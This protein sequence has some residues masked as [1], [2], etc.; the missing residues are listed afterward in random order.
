MLS[1]ELAQLVA[2][3]RRPAL[4]WAARAC[5]PRKRMTVSEH[6]DQHRRLSTKGSAM[7]GKW[8]TDANPP[9]RE[10]MDALSKHSPV[11]EVVLKFPIQFGK[12]EVAV[13]WLGYIMDHDPGP[14]MV[15][16]PGEA[17]ME[18]WI[19]QKLNPAIEEGEVMRRAMTSTKS[20]ESSNQ[21]AFKDFAGGQLFIEHAG[22]PARL[23]SNSVEKLIVDELDEFA[24]Q[25]KGGDDPVEMLEGRTSAFPVTGKRLYISSPQLEGRSRIDAKWKLSDQRRYYVPCPH[26]GHMQPLEWSGLHWSPDASHAWY[27]CRDC[28]CVIEEHHKPQMIRFGRWVAENPGAK[29]RG[30]QINCLYYQ[31]AL[32]PRWAQ[33]A[34]M[35]V[36]AQADPAKLKV[37]V[38][39]RLAE[40]WEDPAMRSVKHNVLRDRAEPYKLRQAPDGVLAIT[41]GVDTQ[42]DR[43]EVQIIGWGRGLAAWTLDYV[44]LP[45]D[46]A[47]ADV[48]ALLTEL[49]NRPIEHAS[50]VLMP[51]EATAIDT[52]GHRGEQVKSY[53]RAA[54]IRR[55]MA[56]FGAVQNNA[57]VLNRGKLVDV[58]WQGKVDPR[59]LTLYQVGTVAIK[60]LLYSRISTDADK[61]PEAR[62]VHLSDQ[63]EPEFFAG[64][65]S[66]TYN[67]SK[68]RFEKRSGVRN[69]PLDTWGYAYAAAHH[70][71]LRL[72]RQ[73]RAEWDARASR[74]VAALHAAPD[75]ARPPI[76]QTT[77]RGP[78]RGTRS[79]GL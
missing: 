19:N 15:C 79:A 54:R 56:I 46:P 50:G 27:C 45:G 73:S 37:F 64:L 61:Q 42:D 44:V 52:G 30:Y 18:K 21:K 71:N 13:N 14:T 74:L 66:E 38:N 70:P 43:L 41:A 48:W 17:S 2:P 26:C 11:Q 33:L 60:H 53:V 39:D 31:F 76:V 7:S 25:L 9:L 28:G 67:P 35:W 69:E 1:T 22:S 72:H 20:R 51:V 16:L 10:P 23:K 8:R 75:P 6:A 40:T 59:G 49:L 5:A 62:L 34:T 12:T 24:Q 3:A 36:A 58:N 78:R 47:N 63:L 65:V 29:I 32:G 68:N 57:P 55:P 4:G 77:P